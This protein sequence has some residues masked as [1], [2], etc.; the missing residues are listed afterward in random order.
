M[1]T[2]DGTYPE[3]FN[4]DLVDPAFGVTFPSKSELALNL[5]TSGRFVTFMGYVAQPDQ[6]DMSNSSTPAVIDPTNPVAGPATDRAV[7]QIDSLGRASCT[8]TN[9]YSGNNGRAAILSDRGGPPELCTAGNAA[10]GLPW[11]PATDGLRNITG[12]VNR[13]GTLTVWGITSTVSGSG[14]NGADPNK[15][16]AIT[17][18]L[19]GAAGLAR[20]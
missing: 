19:G 13:D 20:R 9:A 18:R 3:V 8:E 2:A 11:S 15:L 16:V 6:I 10:T 4:N 7:G 1:A 12:R 14:D 17:D 5:S